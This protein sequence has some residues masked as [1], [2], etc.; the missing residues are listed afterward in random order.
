MTD[1]DRSVLTPVRARERSV[2]G[3][4]DVVIPAQHATAYIE[5]AVDSALSQHGADVHV[6]LV[7]DGGDDHLDALVTSW[8]EPRVT[9][10]R[11]SVPR[12]AAA[13]RNTGVSASDSRWLGFLDADDI[14]P[15]DRFLQ[16]SAAIHDPSWQMAFGHQLIFDDESVPDPA[17][18]LPV[19][20]TPLATLA[21]G[22][23]LHR[24]LF[25]RV[26][27]F[28]EELRLGEFVDWMSRARLDGVEERVVPTIALLRR[29]HA[30][31][32]TRTRRDEYSSYLEVVRRA[33]ARQRAAR[34]Q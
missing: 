5:A 10:L 8:D 12:G 28:D 29:S 17:A 13:A 33:R 2:P 21:G 7:D 25:L 23:L 32:L 14:W 18:D 22:M 16:L 19:E 1:D 30:A 34:G 31:N 11:H 6:V 15:H 3:S 26:G 24:E 27:P 9:C 4:L 20:G